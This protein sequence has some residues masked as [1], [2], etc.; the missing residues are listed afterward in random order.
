MTL[1]IILTAITAVVAA[2]LTLPLVR[3]QEARADARAATLAVL[4]DQLADVDVQLAAGTIP[5]ADA[6]GLRIEIRR[7]MLAAGHIVEDSA[8]PFTSRALSGVAI[9]LVGLVALAA[10]ALY[11]GM[12]KPGLAVGPGTSMAQAPAAP[13]AAP[14]ADSPSDP[15]ADA[16]I[17]RLVTG[18]EARLAEK[19][20]DAE[21]WRM[22][23]WSYYNLRRFDEAAKAYARAVALSPQGPGYQSAYA[24]AL[25][26][27]AQGNV[28]PQAMSAFRLAAAQDGSDARAR[29]Y[30]GIAKAQSGDLKGALDDWISL[31][32]ESAADAPWVPQLRGIIDAT[33]REARIDVSA[34]LAS[35][36][37]P[38]SGGASVIAPPPPASSAPPGVL[39]GPSAEQAAAVQALPPAQQQ[40]MIRGMVEGLAEKLKA[41]PKDE[42]GWLR[43]MRARTVL[44]ERAEARAARDSALAAFATDPAAQSRI[45][46]AAAD[47]GITG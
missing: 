41:N 44:G 17:A 25:V 6:E 4:K 29:Y 37:P 31:L 7:R 46:A 22:L 19:P 45:R 24:E 21:G 39:P 35:L 42:A 1:W 16:E 5:P 2:L 18:L 13:P 40:Q 11:A 30:L 3:R 9:G 32:G 36:R 26:Q 47:M 28:T 8:R 23:G 38:A 27:V 43:L 15:A 33:A 12:G 10:A 14:P 20:E 34:R